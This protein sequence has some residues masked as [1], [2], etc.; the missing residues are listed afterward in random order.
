MARVLTPQD[1]HALMNALV[2]QATGQSTIQ[3][4]NT[5]SFVSAGE[6]VLATGIENTLNS[7]GIVL[8]RSLMAVRPYQAK[9]QIINAL[10]SGIYTNRLRKIS[11]YAKE[12]QA[13]GDYN[14]QLFTNLKTGFTAGQNMN[15]SNQPQSTKSQWEQNAPIPLEMNFGG[16]SVWEE[17]ITRYEDQI[18]VAFRSESEFLEFVSGVMTEKAN[19]IESTKEA[20]NRMTILN[21]I[22]GVYNM[23]AVMPGSAVNLTSEFNSQFGTQYTSEELRTTYL[24]EFLAYFV[25]RFKMDSKYLTERTSKYHWSPVKIV[26]E[27]THVLLRHTPMSRQ[28]AILYAPLFTRA[29]AQVLPEIFNPQYLD[30][31][32][33]EEVNYWQSLDVPAAINI[34]PAIVDTSNGTQ[35]EGDP[36]ELEY[37]VGMLYDQD[38]IMTDYQL[39]TANTTPLEARKRYRNIWWSF[40]RNAINDFTENCIIYYMADTEA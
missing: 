37:V 38:A 18:A 13:S 32:T 17:S 8:G 16:S 34:T 39:D 30:V 21:H 11:F 6:L 31:G 5:S 24:K 22:A 19:D 14:T 33:H 9:L 10:N 2:K 3:V 7:L 23:S 12:A 25:E 26:N 20:F 29:T 1:A 28:R 40:R 36:V 27:V 15:A 35:K 4:T